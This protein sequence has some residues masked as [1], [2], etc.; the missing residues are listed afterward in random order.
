M[1]SSGVDDNGLRLVE[2]GGVVNGSPGGLL[3]K[4]GLMLMAD[5][6]VVFN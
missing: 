2:Y 5:V 1:F 3:N 4:M 6:E